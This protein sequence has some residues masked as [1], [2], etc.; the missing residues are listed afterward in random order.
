MRAGM[1]IGEDRGWR[2]LLHSLS[3]RILLLTILFVMA[4]VALV[5][6]PAVAR[7]HHELLADRVAAAELAVLPF[8][9]APGQQLSPQL[10]TELLARAGVLAVVLVGGG[11]HELIPVG[12]QPP[13]F[14]AVYNAGETGF[15]EEMRNVLRCLA[16]P[17]G[18][19]IRIDAVTGLPQGPSIF[20]VA[21]EEPIRAALY[22]FSA[23]ALL[24]SLFVAG[25]T[26]LLV[27]MSLYLI[28]VRPMQ[29][30]TA[31][32][33]TF[34]ANPEDPSRILEPSGR[35]DE[36]GVAEY[37]LST[38]QREIYGSL[39]QKNRLALLGS[40]VAKIQHDLRNI[41]T[42]AQIA[43]DRLAT[44]EDP[45]VKHVTPRLVAA[46]DRAVALATNTLRYGKAEEPPPQRR[47]IA[48]APLVEDVA[49]SALPERTKVKVENLVPP[50]LE[51]DADP[52][53]LFRLLLN[54][55]KNGRE[56]LDS[57]PDEAR[58]DGKRLT[59][60][61]RRKGDTV[62]ILV[63]DNGPGIAPQLRERLFL[64][65]AGSARSGGTGLGLAIAREL[66]RAHGGDIILL[67]SDETGTR[68]RVV[69][70]DRK[71]D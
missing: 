54:L 6:F 51:V 2:L 8:T 36:I 70:P 45:V 12:Q 41:L 34:R 16:A 59:I 37:E 57:L 68:F 31:A 9:E 25:A 21:N 23:R 15:F 69:I 11:Q 48:L 61:A 67:G 20:V 65:F 38:M 35:K 58:P 1:R 32:M 47:R 3:G 33:I 50:G 66:A 49:A 40:A 4:S 52:D 43:S 17:P 39:Q 28:L 44:S 13:M 42:S 53:Q 26:A 71:D 27:F 7:Y 62:F 22:A 18:R 14:Q 5:Y 30:M 63:R 64:P 55:V 46:L 10:R 56:A 60:E 24:I 19:V 29:R